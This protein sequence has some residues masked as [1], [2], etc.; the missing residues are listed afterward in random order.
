MGDDLFFA[1]LFVGI[2]ATMNLV[3]A[4][5]W[6]R[7]ARRATRYEQRLFAAPTADDRRVE[8]LENALASVVGQVDRLTNGQEFLSRVLGERSNRL[9]ERPQVETPH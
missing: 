2:S 5:A 3:F 9:P 6:F 7:S 4:V 8:Q 1:L